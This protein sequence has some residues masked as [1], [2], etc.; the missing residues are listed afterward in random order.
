MATE[1]ERCAE[2]KKLQRIDDAF[3]RGD[4]DDL[5]AAVDD[6]AAVPNGRL[7]YGLTRRTDMHGAAGWRAA[8]TTITVAKME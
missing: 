8:C 7:G 5:R 4:L 1:E 6:P 3:Q 2:A